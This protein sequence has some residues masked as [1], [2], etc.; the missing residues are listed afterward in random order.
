[1]FKMCNILNFINN[2]VSDYLEW[3]CFMAGIVTTKHVKG[4]FGS[5]LDFCYHSPPF[6]INRLLN[7]RK[8]NLECC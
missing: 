3:N 5:D 7:E 8:L 1:M 2:R 4:Y 6:H